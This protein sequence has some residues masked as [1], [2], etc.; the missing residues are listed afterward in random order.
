[1]LD[2]KSAKDLPK[3]VAWAR[4]P[5]PDPAAFADTLDALATLQQTPA[6]APDPAPSTP[7]SS[8]SDSSAP[9]SSAP[10]ATASDQT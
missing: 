4:T 9:D 2:P 1:M 3:L 10:G 7:D 8:T 5:A 6:T